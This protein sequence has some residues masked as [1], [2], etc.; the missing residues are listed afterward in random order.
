VIGITN[1]FNFID[2][3]DGVAVGIGGIAVSFFLLVTLNSPQVSLLRLLT[4]LLGGCIGLF[5]FNMTPARL[6][7]GDSGAQTL[8]FLLAAIGIIYN[9][10]HFPQ[11]SSWFLPILVLGVPIFDTCLVVFS[12][13]RHQTHIYQAGHD[14]TYHRLVGLGLSSTHAVAIMHIATIVLGCL[15][16][17]ALH[18]SPL[19]ANVFFG[20]ILLIGVLLYIY[21]E[22]KV[23]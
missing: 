8:G 17:I 4:L 23:G 19:F 5:F 15:A 20:L 1:A 18:L 11:A 10:V 21:L 22:R 6:F 13:L 7:L 2:S 14:H 3:M 12:R 9:P 16:F